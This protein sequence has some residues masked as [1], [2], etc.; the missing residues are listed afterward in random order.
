[1]SIKTCAFIGIIIGFYFLIYSIFVGLVNPIPAKGDSWDYHI[2]IAKMILSG[3]IIHPTHVII[4]QW[5]YPGSAEIFNSFF[6]L[7]HIP[8][9]LTNILAVI[10][11]FFIC[12]KLAGVFG[13]DYYESLFFAVSI[14]T[15]NVFVRWYNSVNVDIWLVNFFLLAIIL[16]KRPRKKINYFLWL[17][18][19]LGM[20]IGT[21]FT[22][23]YYLI[24]LGLLYGRNLFSFIS[25]KRVIFFFVPF[26]LLGL[27]WYLRNWIIFHNPFYP[28][29]FLGLPYTINFDKHIW[30]V[31]LKKPKEMLDAFFSE[32]KLWLLALPMAIAFVLKRYIFEKGREFSPTVELICI[33]LFGF[34]IFLLSPTD[35][36]SWI[37]VSS[38]RYSYTTFIPIILA[39]FLFAKKYKRMNILIILSIASMIMVT[40]FNYY[41][42]LVIIYAGL[43]VFCICIIERY[44]KRLQRLFS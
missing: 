2:P 9:T 8:L 34:I 36:K 29:Y 32:Y 17:G 14:V 13:L 6:I 25:I 26:S 42:K 33:G 43:S 18:A 24:L 3:E 27:S 28:L 19:V 20:L 40:S 15:L 41:P 10:I 11:L 23:F 39:I 4:N 22:G 37:M 38:M 31:G 35:T 1:M 12:W 30:D 7:L 21:K 5:Y 44:K 16:L